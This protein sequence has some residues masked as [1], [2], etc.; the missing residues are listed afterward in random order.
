M[1]RRDFFKFG[2]GGQAWLWGVAWP[3]AR[4][5]PPLP[6]AEVFTATPGGLR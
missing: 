2:F 5:I 1:N 6:L 4:I 3:Q